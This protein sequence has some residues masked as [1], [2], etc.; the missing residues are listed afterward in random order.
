LKKKKQLKKLK[1]K[2]EKRQGSSKKRP[3]E[4]AA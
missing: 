4:D 2:L 1:G 3:L